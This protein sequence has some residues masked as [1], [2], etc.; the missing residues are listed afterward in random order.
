[1]SFDIL[2]SFFQ[3]IKNSLK[4]KDILNKVSKISTST[5]LI[6]SNKS[7]GADLVTNNITLAT[8]SNIKSHISSS[9]LGDLQYYFKSLKL[10]WSN[11]AVDTSNKTFSFGFYYLRGLVVILFIDACL[12]DDEPL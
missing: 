2:K 4:S 5:N 12:T 3:N 1:M 11:F 6:N 9:N 8:K 10:Y 7:L